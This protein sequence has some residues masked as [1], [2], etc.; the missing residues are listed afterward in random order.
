M[1]RVPIIIGAKRFELINGSFYQPDQI[2]YWRSKCFHWNRRTIERTRYIEDPSRQLAIQ[3]KSNDL[4]RNS[5]EVCNCDLINADLSMTRS[6]IQRW[7]L[8]NIHLAARRIT[9]QTK[10]DRLIANLWM[11]WIR[12]NSERIFELNIF[13]MDSE[14][15]K[16][17][18]ISSVLQWKRLTRTIID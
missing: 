7:I 5:V 16:K 11:A 14:E 15:S 12:W 10:E 6:K 2:P 13:R 9:E 1:L 4:L 17:Q 18:R 8:P 3:M